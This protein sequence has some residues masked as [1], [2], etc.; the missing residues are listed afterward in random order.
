MLDIAN[1]SSWMNSR[2]GNVAE[3]E[4]SKGLPR[5]FTPLAG[6]RHSLIENVLPEIYGNCCFACLSHKLSSWQRM[7]A[8]KADLTPDVDDKLLLVAVD[9][10]S[11]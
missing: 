9:A 3:L 1:N 7:N 8:C 6:V 4:V 2:S 11:N 5:P 10:A